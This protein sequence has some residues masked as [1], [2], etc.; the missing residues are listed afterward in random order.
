MCSGK[1]GKALKFSIFDR[2]V[3]LPERRHRLPLPGA[4]LLDISSYSYNLSIFIL[5][6]ITGSYCHY[7]INVWQTKSGHSSPT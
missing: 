7:V 5:Q 4:I 2:S 3:A 6:P 1:M